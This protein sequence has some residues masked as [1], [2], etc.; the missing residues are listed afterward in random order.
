MPTL[1]V[2]YGITVM[3]YWVDIDRHSL[4][5]IHVRYGEYEAS[6]D[7]QTGERLAGD[8]PRKKLN[9]VQTWIE[10]HREELLANWGLAVDGESISK[11]EPLK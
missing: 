11:I 6:V 5:H 10:L 2:F 7:I 8:F 3:M 9:L 4:P 1:S